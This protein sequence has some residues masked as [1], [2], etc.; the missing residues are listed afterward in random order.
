METEE[1]MRHEQTAEAANDVLKSL[2][3]LINSIR[4]FGLYFTRKPC[5]PVRVGNTSKPSRRYI[6]GCYGWNPARIYATIVLVLSWFNALRNCIIFDGTETLGAY[7]FTKLGTIPG[8]L[9]IAIL[10]TTYY[11]ASHNESLEIIFRQMNSSTPGFSA[12]YRYSQKA[13]AVTVISWLL[14]S[15]GITAYTY[16]LFTREHYNDFSLWMIINTFHVSKL[17]ENIL[18]V[19][20]TMLQLQ[21]TASWA[22]A[23]AMNYTV[24]SFLY[25]Q[26]DQLNDD[27]SKCI[28]DRGKFSGNFGQFR[29]RHQAIS[30]LV[31]EADRFLMISNAANFCCQIACIIFVF[32]IV[33]FYLDDTVLLDPEYAVV[34]VS[35]LSLSVLGLLWTAGLA[36]HLNQ[37]ASIYPCVK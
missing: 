18:K 24:V 34:P 31:Q 16:F 3:P 4:P 35:W 5:V 27:F 19:I 11:I 23:H 1:S 13:R 32:Y 25:D 2:S 17:C 36:I 12:K 9:L 6:R 22:F 37:T 10:H 8:V 28:D 26:F 29:R 21:A 33:V 20:S 14:I 15:F 30:R 7:L